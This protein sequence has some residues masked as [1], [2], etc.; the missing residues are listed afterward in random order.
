[1]TETGTETETDRET[2]TGT[3]TETDRETGT[4]TETDRKEESARQ[5]QKKTAAEIDR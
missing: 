5:R 1:M 3:E 2:G 4:G